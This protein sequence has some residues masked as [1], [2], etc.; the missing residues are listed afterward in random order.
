M[1]FPLLSRRTPGVRHEGGMWYD[2]YDTQPRRT[3]GGGG[4]TIFT[5]NLGVRQE[6]GVEMSPYLITSEAHKCIRTE[7]AEY[8]RG[9]T[10]CFRTEPTTPGRDVIWSHRG[11]SVRSPRHTAHHL[12]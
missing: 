2:T 5:L 11:V 7:L 3:P 9:G 12:Q 4:D 1:E 10:G 8:P 6:M